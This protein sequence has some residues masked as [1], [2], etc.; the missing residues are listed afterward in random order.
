MRETG[1]DNLLEPVRAADTRPAALHAVTTWHGFVLSRG[2]WL[3]RLPYS[4]RKNTGWLSWLQQLQQPLLSCTVFSV[5]SFLLYSIHDVSEVNVSTYKNIQGRRMEKPSSQWADSCNNGIAIFS[6]HL[7]HLVANHYNNGTIT[8]KV[9]HCARTLPF[10][11]PFLLLIPVTA[12][13]RVIWYKRSADG[14]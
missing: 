8:P 2:R 11:F 10:L 9:C 14:Q 13:Y 4:G 12:C 1:D 3:I 5:T 7:G 6:L